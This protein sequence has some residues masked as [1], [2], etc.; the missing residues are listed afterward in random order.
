[1]KTFLHKMIPA[2]YGLEEGLPKPWTKLFVECLSGHSYC[3]PFSS[4][5]KKEA[6]A[7]VIFNATNLNIIVVLTIMATE[8][9]VRLSSLPPFPLCITVSP[10]RP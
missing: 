8:I 10:S 3:I 9:M 5:S 7:T 6:M 4:K 2:V 1:M